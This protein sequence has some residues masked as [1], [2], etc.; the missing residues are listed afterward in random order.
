MRFVVVFGGE[1]GLELGD[2]L[3]ELGAGLGGYVDGDAED[4]GEAEEFGGC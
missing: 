1:E 4:V 2:G 3:A